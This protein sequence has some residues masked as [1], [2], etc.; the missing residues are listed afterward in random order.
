MT[1]KVMS[2]PKISFNLLWPAFS[3][4]SLKVLSFNKSSKRHQTDLKMKVLRVVSASLKPNLEG[5][6]RRAA[7]S[8]RIFPFS[9]HRKNN[10]S[11]KP[12]KEVK[13]RHETQKKHSPESSC[14]QALLCTDTWDL[15]LLPQTQNTTPLPPPF[16]PDRNVSSKDG[17]LSR[18]W[19]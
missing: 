14:L 8:E 17:E 3:K 13:K 19:V 4:P 10:R 6:K 15:L 16:A 18:V 9:S 5:Q 11:N 1:H 7:V 2:P 12:Q